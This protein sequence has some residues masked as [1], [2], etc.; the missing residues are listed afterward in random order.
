[1][2]TII[3]TVAVARPFMKKGILPLTFRAAKR[4]LK[5][6]GAGIRDVG[7][8]IYSGVYTENYL[9]E[10]ALAALIQNRLQHKSRCRRFFNKDLGDV[11]SF[12]LYN[13]GGGVISAIQVIDGFIQSGEI[14]S[15]LVIAGDTKPVSG[16]SENY[17]YSP[18]AGAILL[19]KDIENRGFVKFSTETF[20]EFIND[21]ESTTNWDTGSFRFITNQKS[22]YL[23]N[24]VEC[25]EKSIQQSFNE[26][27]LNWDEIDLVVASTS[28]KGFANELQKK[29]GLNNKLIQVNR[30]EKIFSAG[31]IFSLDK[32]FSSQK[33]MEAKNILFLTVGAGITVSLSLYRNKL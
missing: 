2:G 33:F 10:P 19:S 1:M 27:N 16:S 9:K 15:G 12:D 26:E 4:C 21:L 20:S 30:N 18:G 6:A 24:C 8:L 14:E 3:K 17:N 5:N 22:N 7:M 11:F 32:V 23:K 31:V 29:T 25:A 13:G 28:P